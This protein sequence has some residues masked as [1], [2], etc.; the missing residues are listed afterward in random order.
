[1]LKLDITDDQATLSVAPIGDATDT[2][3][4]DSVLTRLNEAGVCCGILPDA[5]DEAVQQAARNKPVEDVIVAQQIEPH[6]GEPARLTPIL[7]HQQIVAPGDTIATIASGVEAADGKTIL[8]EP[9]AAPAGPAADPAIG[10]HVQIEANE[11]K[12]AVYGHLHITDEEISVVPPV[13]VQDDGML[14][15]IDIH[16]KSVAETP[17]DR[18]MLLGSLTAAGVVYGIDEEKLLLVLDQALE[19]DSVLKNE[20]AAEGTPGT[21]GADAT[22]EH[23]IEVEQGTGAKRDDGSIDYRARH[24]IR[25]VREGVL[26][27]RRIPPQAGT[28][29]VDVFGKMNPA[30]VGNDINMQAGQNTEQRGDE[31]WSTMDGAMMIISGVVNILD[32]YSVPGD[33]DLEIGNLEAKKGAIDI[34]GTVCSG[35]T[36]TAASH[37][38]VKGLVDNATLEAGGDIQVGGGVLHAVSGIIRAKGGVVAKFAQNAKI[39]A[40][41]DIFIAGAAVNC[42]LVASAQIIVSGNRARLIGGVAS[43]AEGIT[44][45]QLGSEAEVITR[46]EVGIDHQAID[47]I[48]REIEQCEAAIEAGEATDDEKKALVRRLHELVHPEHRNA[49]I[50]VSGTVY[51]GVTVSLYGND[52]TISKAAGHC[53]IRLDREQE[54]QISPL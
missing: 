4:A 19:S 23:L 13:E 53:K 7:R 39:R 15:W 25:S 14:A 51:P 16:P 33:I 17:I 40:G 32:V 37:I 22:I 44:V 26:I 1:M 42:D 29:Q 46:A 30:V 41:G 31:I 27:C 21:R 20:P 48:K 54:I 5:I 9:I 43:A 8:G 18:D 12:A 49:I 47:R 50:E 2:F 45:Q 28:P 11:L 36:V 6:P 35:F 3:S 38:I 52:H 10:A 34:G 24:M